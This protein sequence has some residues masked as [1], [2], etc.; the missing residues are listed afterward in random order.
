MRDTFPALVR[1]WLDEMNIPTLVIKYEDMIDDLHTQLKK[2]LHFLQVPY[3]KEQVEC[4]LKYGMSRYHRRKVTGFDHYTPEL[5]KLVVDG[6][7]NVEPIL[8]KHNVTYRSVLY[9]GN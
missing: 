8:N 3:S 2:M 7:K 1:Y 5:R 6:L 4:V 9:N